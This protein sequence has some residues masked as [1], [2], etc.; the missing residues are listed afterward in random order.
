NGNSATRND[1]GY[2][3]NS[4]QP[5][6]KIS[7][8]WSTDCPSANTIH[9]NEKVASCKFIPCLSFC[10]LSVN[11]Q[12]ISSQ[13]MTSSTQCDWGGDL[14]HPS[15]Q[16]GYVYRVMANAT[17]KHFS[18]VQN[19]NEPDFASHNHIG[20]LWTENSIDWRCEGFD[21]SS[22]YTPWTSGLTLEA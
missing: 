7:M 13:V 18:D 5:W 20:D 3:S 19:S 2:S 22:A 14:V 12:S 4:N 8:S 21:S 11:E 10:A 17:S 16:N 6:C 1:I 9:Q 15:T